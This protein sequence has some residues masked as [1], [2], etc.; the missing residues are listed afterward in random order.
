MDASPL[1][2]QRPKRGRKCY[3]T[4][5]FSGIPKGSRTKSEPGAQKR[6]ERLRHPFILGGPKTKG[7]KNTA[8]CLTPT[9]SGAQSRAEMPPHPN[10][11]GA[12]LNKAGQ[13]QNWLPHPCLLE[14]PK[15]GKNATSPLHSRGMPKKRQTKAELAASHPFGASK[16]GG[17]STSPLHS[18][19]SP[20]KAGQNQNW[21]PHRCLLEGSKE[22]RSATSPMRSTG[23]P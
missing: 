19:G 6:A 7:A 1:P 21:L 11:V 13:N 15:E 22:G 14:G 18:R 5:A 9:F 4:P 8:G 2:S 23:I 17:N 20:N 3:L 16:E 10:V 12:S